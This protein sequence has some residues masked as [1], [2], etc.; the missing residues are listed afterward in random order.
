[1]AGV[2][3]AGVIVLALLFVVEALPLRSIEGWDSLQPDPSLHLLALV[4]FILLLG[5]FLLLKHRASPAVGLCVL[6]ALG[7]AVYAAVEYWF[8]N[9]G[10]GILLA[11]ALLW[12][13]GGLRY[14]LRIPALLRRYV[15]PSQ[16]PPPAQPLEPSIPGPLP[17]DIGITVSNPDR[18][19]RRLIVVCASGGGIRAATWTAAIL[20]QL[21][22]IA[23][24]RAATRLITGAS[25]GMMGAASWLAA[26]ANPAV[27]IS[28]E[29]LME[30]VAQDSLTPV[31]RQLM[32]HD[33]PLAFIA[34]NN[35]QDRALALET[36]WCQNL[37]RVG[38][39][40]QVPLGELR[41]AEESGQLPSIVFSPMLIEDGRRL[42]I[43]N[44]DLRE[45]SDHSVR[46]LS[47][48]ATG[49][50]P[51]T[52][53]ASRTAY[54]LWQISAQDWARF[55]LS[56]AARL[57]AA[58]PYVSSAVLLPTEPRLHVVDAGYYDNYG[59]ELA[60]NWLRELFQKCGSDLKGSI[61]GILVLQ[62]RDN[63]SELSVNPETHDLREAMLKRQSSHSSRLW[64]ALE[65]LSSP[66]AGFLAARESV[67]LFRNDAQLETLSHLYSSAFGEDFLTTT[68]FE[69]G[70]EVSLS[71]QLAQEEVDL[72]REQANSKGIQLKIKAIESWLHGTNYWGASPVSRPSLPLS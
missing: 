6:L 26:T 15:A 48:K 43:S 5:A 70:G 13:A 9:A 63:V 24:F 20:G 47:S 36:A 41:G 65:G 37:K 39:D 11:M 72:L 58:F 57:S 23:G 71:W 30:A 28:W 69:F 8:R 16:Y 4:A 3:A 60:G 10:L 17:F 66:P 55:P 42:I 40:L 53:L 52:G 2:A 22:K 45:V 44:L 14:K 35:L 7:L 61:S 46:W 62:I 59:L 67:M 54:Q 29:S 56:T 21:D 33:I 38:I 51:T 34:R 1:M 19:K 32:F 50:K 18:P 25:G 12:L 49:T 64:R 27:S 68:V 31:A